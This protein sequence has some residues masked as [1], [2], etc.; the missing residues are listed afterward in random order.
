MSNG[1]INIYQCDECWTTV[2]GHHRFCHNCGAFQGFDAPRTS[3]FS[4]TNIQSSFFFYIIYLFIC[5]LVQFTDWFGSYDRLFWVEIVMAAITLLYVKIN[6]Q[7]IKPLLRF[8]NFNF[9]RLTGAISLAII[10]SA[11]VNIIVTKMNL[12]FFGT[13]ISFYS[14]YKIY[15]MPAL[16]MLY[17]IAVNP[18]IFEELAFRGIIYNSLSVFLNERL[19]ILVTGIAFAAIHLSFLSLFWLIPFGILLGAMRKTYNTIWYGV[20][21]HFTFNLVACLF[22]LYKEGALW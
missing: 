20:I 10:F 4:N 13:E 2:K 18:A 9:T 21:L 5:L 1:S 14:T 16:V 12:S 7:S 6:W 22:D 3:I 8:N 15:K 11:I 19:V 17:S